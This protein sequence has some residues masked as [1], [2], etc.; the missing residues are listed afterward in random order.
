MKQ[1]IYIL[2]IVPWLIILGLVLCNKP[3][4]T[5][6]VPRSQFAA[7]QQ[8]LNDTTEA[9]QAFRKK[10][11][12][13]LDNANTMAIQASE[14]LKEDDDKLNDKK[15]TIKWLLSELDKADELKQDS[16]WVSVSPIYKGDCDSLRRVNKVLVNQ[17]ENYQQ[18][19]QQQADILAYEVHLRDSIIEGERTFKSAFKR[20]ADSC[21]IL[22]Q[23]D[24]KEATKGLKIEKTKSAVSIAIAAIA[25][26]FAALKK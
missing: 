14:Q 7:L 5:D 18:D 19:G 9:Y 4:Q 22:G 8:R 26:I 3:K 12:S 11:D 24:L 21:F 15:E 23:Q 13:S 17:I 2:A 1:L 6:M 10:S 16:T 25:I 20:K